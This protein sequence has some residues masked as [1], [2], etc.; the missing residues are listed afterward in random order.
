[1]FVEERKHFCLVDEPWIPVVGHG[2]KSLLEIF[3]DDQYIDL[4][5][6]AVQKIA[7]VKLFIAIAE[8]AASIASEEEWERLGHEGLSK[9]VIEYL[10]EHRDDFYL[11][12]PKPFLQMPVLRNH[13][14]ECKVVDLYSI[15]TPDVEPPDNNNTIL[16]S[17]Q[18]KQDLTDADKAI[19]VVQLMNYALA[20]KRV[21]KI[22]ALSATYDGKGS[23]A[24]A[25]PSLGG[26]N[27][28]LQTFIKGGS[29]RK[30]VWLNY[31]TAEDL[32]NINSNLCLEARPPWEKKPESED[33]DIAIKIQ[34]SVY[35][36]LV[37]LSRFVLLEDGGIKYVEGLQYPSSVSDGYYEP[38][39]TIGSNKSATAIF[40]DPAKKPWR[41]LQAL[42]QSVYYTSE[43]S[44]TCDL[45]RR[46]WDR[47][48]RNTSRFSIW[49]GGLKVRTNSGDQSVKQ[50]DD[51]LDSEVEF[52]SDVVDQNYYLALC[53]LISRIDSLASSLR[54]AIKRYYDDFGLA[55]DVAKNALSAFWLEADKYESRIV[56]NCAFEDERKV[57]L[58]EIR[59][60]AL[61]L[62][63]ETCPH[64]IGREVLIWA[65]YRKNVGYWR[66]DGKS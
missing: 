4:S 36:W 38:F 15:Y 17:S 31:F 53:G 52:D 18:C 6:T 25:G 10:T 11:Y 47:T 42:L 65:K 2:R 27:G 59:S 3:S 12:G 50:S 44:F 48:K 66:K 9:I 40:V 26:Y 13:S 49:C 29:I 33:D 22:G 41:S 57:L 32:K 64:D 35:A 54:N 24:K 14:K 37:G 34:S 43:A 19:M 45:L 28:Y 8:G 23:S 63:D 55:G 51:F 1:M 62:F 46:F 7:L 60:I 16:F 5:C 30:T 56:E 20:G 21:S 58:D 61:R 39:I